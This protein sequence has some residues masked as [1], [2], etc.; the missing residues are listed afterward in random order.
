MVDNILEKQ[1]NEAI[2]RMIA[3]KLQESVIDHFRNDGLITCSNEGRLCN[4]SQ[5]YLS[6]VREWECKTGNLVFHVIINFSEVGILLSYLFVGTDE[7]LWFRERLLIQKNR[8]RAY[9]KIIDVDIFSDY[10]SIGIINNYGGLVRV[11]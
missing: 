7:C 2:K 5:E 6:L 4:L 10:I 3:L 11:S 8:Y 1:M 9:V